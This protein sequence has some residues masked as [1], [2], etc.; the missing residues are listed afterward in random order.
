MFLLGYLK[1]LFNSTKFGGVTIEHPIEKAFECGN[2]DYFKFVNEF[3]IPSQRALVYLDIQ[4]ELGQKI[5]NKYLESYFDS[6]LIAINKGNLTDVAYLTKL[7]K[8]RQENITILDTW[9]KI[10]SVLYFDSNENPYNYDYEYNEKKIA[11]WKRNGS[12]LSFFL[13]THLNGL[14]TF[15]NFSEKD[16]K[17]YLKGQQVQLIQ[18]LNYRL[19]NIL[20][21]EKNSEKLTK[22]KS[23]LS[24][25]KE[26]ISLI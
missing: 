21:N 20:E 23:D 22:L 24:I 25:T 7:A 19:D 5:D 18:I 15:L 8:Q 12:A 2:V 17:D 26:L 9:Y 14:V 10:A 6:V 11:N 16:M 13:Q 3:N 4:A 1:R